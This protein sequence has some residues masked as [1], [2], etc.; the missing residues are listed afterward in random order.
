[1]TAKSATACDN[2]KDDR[3]E[4]RQEQ[5]KHDAENVPSPAECEAVQWDTTAELAKDDAKLKISNP[6]E[7]QRRH[8]NE[9]F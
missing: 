6:S 2:A 9:E 1:M 8:P 4:R 7:W 3:Q 5:A